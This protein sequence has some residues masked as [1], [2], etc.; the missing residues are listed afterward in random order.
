MAHVT[1]SEFDIIIRLLTEHYG[2]PVFHERLLKANAL[3][4][5]KRPP[6]WQP[7]ANQLYQLSAGLRRDHPA[8]YAIEL[9]WQDLVSSNTEED[10]QEALD[11]LAEGINAC[12]TEKFEI[13]PDKQTDLISA[14][15]SYYHAIAAVSSEDVAYTEIL[16]RA[17]KDVAQFLREHKAE[18]LAVTPAPEQAP[19][20]DTPASEQEDLQPNAPDEGA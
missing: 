10:Q 8:R 13:I 11:T 19:Q 4:S 6:R 1:S 18:V 5:R 20:D 14:L 17:S 9:L 12:L 15:G 16:L 7:L 2:L 3:V